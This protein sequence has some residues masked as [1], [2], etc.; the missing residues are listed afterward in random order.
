MSYPSCGPEIEWL[1]SSISVTAALISRFLLDL[2]ALAQQNDHSGTVGGTS[3]Y[4][5]SELQNTQ[6]LSEKG[7][8]GLGGPLG[9][10][11]RSYKTGEFDDCDTKD[12]EMESFSAGE[13]PAASEYSSDRTLNPGP[14]SPM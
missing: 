13:T 11:Y 10:T 1:I 9:T 14:S 3:I 6:Y 7:F 12:F 5:T 8:E 2:C 4:L